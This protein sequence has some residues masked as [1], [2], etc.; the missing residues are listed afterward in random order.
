MN[1]TASNAAGRKLRR[2]EAG[3]TNGTQGTLKKRQPVAERAR[4]STDGLQCDAI[5]VRTVSS[6]VRSEIGLLT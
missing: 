5:S 1:A 2:E 6:S 3:G 4:V